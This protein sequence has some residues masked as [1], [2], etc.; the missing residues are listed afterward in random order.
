MIGNENLENKMK[1]LEQKYSSLQI[2]KIIDN[3]GSQK[4]SWIV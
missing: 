4:V 3:H 2:V 1:K